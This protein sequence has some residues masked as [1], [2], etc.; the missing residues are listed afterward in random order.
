M[1]YYISRDAALNFDMSINA[2]PDK[3]E[4]I[5]EGMALYAEYI[6]QIPTA[7]IIDNIIAAVQRLRA[8]LAVPNK[9][10]D[11]GIRLAIQTIRN[12]DPKLPHYAPLE[13]KS[14]KWIQSNDGIPFCPICR[15]DSANGQKTPFCAYCGTH[16]VSITPET[17]T[18][19]E[20]A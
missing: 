6:K 19:P 10:I 13:T 8:N 5:T 3:I 7:V 12:F 17:P 15:R 4:A 1:T 20:N 11:Y 16:M 14:A 9:H 18:L 2:D